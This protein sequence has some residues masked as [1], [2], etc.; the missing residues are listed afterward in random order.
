[1]STSSSPYEFEPGRNQDDFGPTGSRG[2]RLSESDRG[3]KAT[4]NHNNQATHNYDQST[5]NDGSHQD[6]APF[7]TAAFLNYLAAR[8]NDR[9]ANDYLASVGDDGRTPDDYYRNT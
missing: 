6:T 7:D 2:Q 8:D 1:M 5:N 9:T 4:S 3:S